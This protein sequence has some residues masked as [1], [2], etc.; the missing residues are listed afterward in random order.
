M[1][2]SLRETILETL[3][4]AFL[5][6]DAKKSSNVIIYH[7]TYRSAVQH[8]V[9]HATKKGYE[10]NEHDHQNIPPKPGPGKTNRL[11]LGL[12]KNGKPHKKQLHVQV[13]NRDKDTNTYELNH[14]IS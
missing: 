8:A 14:Y 2:E 7:D 10:V 1:T 3:S 9:D 12:S 4:A 6:E 11:H 13:Y 5:K